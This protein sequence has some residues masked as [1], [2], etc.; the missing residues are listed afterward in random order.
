MM[1]HM[2]QT[3]RRRLVRRIAILVVLCALASTAALLA[4]RARPT[5]DDPVQT[6]NRGV[7]AFAEGLP[8]KA[9]DEFRRVAENAP[10]GTEVSAV[11]RYNLATIL[12]HEGQMESLTGA[13][14]MLED[15]LR[16]RP[17]DQQARRNLE[18]VIAKLGMILQSK[19][20]SAEAAE[21]ALDAPSFAQSAK[22]DPSTGGELG[23]GGA[24]AA[25]ESEY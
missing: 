7:A 9:A 20:S 19:A 22:Q 6:Y 4:Q 17:F 18:I 5:D 3:T 8:M 12:A 23:A 21:R 15:V 1:W 13:R 25:D 14:S 10:F 16:Q 24:G 2:T 11:A